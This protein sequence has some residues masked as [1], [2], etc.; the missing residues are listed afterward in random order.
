M[1]IVLR[2]CVIIDPRLAR[3]ELRGQSPTY[4]DREKEVRGWILYL[5]VAFKW[6]DR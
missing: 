5:I 1:V 2:G 6:M 4:P 3:A